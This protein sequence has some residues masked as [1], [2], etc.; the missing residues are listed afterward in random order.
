MYNVKHV[1]LS[2]S[3][4]DNLLILI[5]ESFNSLESIRFSSS[6]A[7]YLSSKTYFRQSR[8][9]INSIRTL[10]FDQTCRN[11]I[12]FVRLLPNLNKLI[13]NQTLL[14]DL[15]EQVTSDYLSKIS[16][17]HVYTFQQIYLENIINSFPNLNYLKLK[18]LLTNDE[19]PI[20]SYIDNRCHHKHLPVSVCDVLDKLLKSQLNRLKLIEIGCYFERDEQ[21]LQGILSRLIKKRR[22]FNCQ[23]H[24]HLEDYKSTRCGHVQ[25][26]FF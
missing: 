17:L 15:L 12:P 6:T 16:E 11:Q 23:F 8:Y 5:R 2:C 22:F 13:I 7:E 24:I 9:L 14:N 20:R 21:N 18:T 4:T 1:D 3:I 19:G 10:I 26:L 25:I